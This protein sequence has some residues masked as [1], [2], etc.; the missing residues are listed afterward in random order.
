M[1]G[2]PCRCNSRTVW[3]SRSTVQSARI[4]RRSGSCDGRICN[5]HLPH[6][7]LRSR[8]RTRN[9]EYTDVIFVPS[10]L[11]DLN[12]LDRFVARAFEHHRTR[13]TNCVRLLEKR[14]ILG[15]QLGDP[16]VEI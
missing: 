4:L 16:G 10:W 5:R 14:D 1:E 6:V 7:A 15:A 12:Q 2:W 8:S 3:P 11:S 9:A 13:L